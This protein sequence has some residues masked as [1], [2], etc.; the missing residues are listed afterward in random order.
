M[1]KTEV[2]LEPWVLRTWAKQALG[3]CNWGTKTHRGSRAGVVEWSG[4]VGTRVK[5]YLSEKWSLTL[6]FLGKHG[7][8]GRALQAEGTACVEKNL[9]VAEKNV[10]EA[11]RKPVRLE[12]WTVL[13]SGKGLLNLTLRAQRPWKVLSQGSVYPVPWGQLVSTAFWFSNHVLA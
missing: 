2:A 4:G 13:E 12:R 1:E 9:E 5:K 3:V 10:P 7:E 11:E 8:E 6:N